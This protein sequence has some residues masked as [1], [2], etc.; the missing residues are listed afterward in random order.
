MVYHPL[1]DPTA[2]SNN[3]HLSQFDT[4]IAIYEEIHVKPSLFSS[5]LSINERVL[6]AALSTKFSA[7]LYGIKP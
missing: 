6:A 7:E 5:R 3:G 4:F 2:Y 1:C